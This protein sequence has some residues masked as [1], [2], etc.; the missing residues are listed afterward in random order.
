[1]RA[2]IEFFDVMYMSTHTGVFMQ[3]PDNIYTDN[4]VQ[5]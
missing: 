5:M 2:D 3:T 4:R 1:M